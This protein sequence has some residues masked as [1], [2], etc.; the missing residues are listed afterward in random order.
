MAKFG[1]R[2]MLPYKLERRVIGDDIE[3]K[4]EWKFRMRI[5]AQGLPAPASERILNQQQ[6]EHVPA[7]LRTRWSPDIADV[8]GD[9]RLIDV[10]KKVWNIL[11]VEESADGKWLHMMIC[12]DQQ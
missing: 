1:F 3:F 5:L 12:R 6:Y 10:L 4:D 2:Q 11:G 7:K 8:D 9:H